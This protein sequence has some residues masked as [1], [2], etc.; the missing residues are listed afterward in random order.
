[1][2]PSAPKVSGFV[3]VII[4]PSS[5]VFIEMRVKGPLDDIP[6][7]PLGLI[8][9]AKRIFTN[10]AKLTS[11]VLREGVSVRFEALGMFRRQNAKAA[12]WGGLVVGFSGWEI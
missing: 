4:L 12:E 10:A 11:L 9:A 6:V 8:G 2:Q 5:V 7:A 3:G 1:M